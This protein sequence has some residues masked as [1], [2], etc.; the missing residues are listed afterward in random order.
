MT[1]CCR[2]QWVAKLGGRSFE[3]GRSLEQQMLRGV[4]WLIFLPFFCSEGGVKG[5][6][7]VT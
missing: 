1:Q 4:G 7:S 2:H 5:E 3:S 6:V